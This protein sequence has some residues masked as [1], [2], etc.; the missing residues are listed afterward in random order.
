[1]K[2]FTFG[3]LILSTGLI[4][5]GCGG[6]DET[7]S[8]SEEKAKEEPK[9]AEQ[10]E[11]K[12]EIPKPEKDEAGNTILDVVGQ[13]AESPEVTAEL[14]KIK[15]VNETLDIAPLTVK[16]KNIKLLK[17]SNMTED[18]KEG[19]KLAA[20]TD[21]IGDEVTYLQIAYE[22]ENKEEKNIEW[23]DLMNV[24][25][26]K[27][28]QIDAQMKDFITDDSEL[29]SEFLGKVKKEY[30]DGLILKNGD[31]NKVKLIFGYTTDSTSYED[32]TPEQQ[33]EYSFE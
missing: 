17:L 24:V 31:I 27:G 33:V 18:Y 19:L 29:D 5:S 22:A 14:I 23:Y 15:E 1:M 13:K 21:T 8:V 11:V 7:T 26:D 3:G 16:V 10:K 25:T 2:R 9:S 12:N 30:T 6:S 20:D 32:I 4:L 28:E